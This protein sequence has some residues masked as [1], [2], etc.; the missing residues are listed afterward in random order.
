MT[1]YYGISDEV[2]RLFSRLAENG[3][4]TLERDL[5]MLPEGLRMAHHGTEYLGFTI[6]EPESVQIIVSKRLVPNCD[7]RKIELPM[8]R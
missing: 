1:E 5:S 4:G 8:G 2:K 6:P 3:A 7:T